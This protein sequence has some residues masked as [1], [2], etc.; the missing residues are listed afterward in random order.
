MTLAQPNGNFPEDTPRLAAHHDA[1]QRDGTMNA[2]DLTAA[3]AQRCD[4][5]HQTATGWQACC[6]AHE[7]S[8]PSLAITPGRDKVLLKCHA[9]CTV[10]AIVTALGMTMADLFLHQPTTHGRK[11][12]VKV[13]DYLDANGHVL[14]QTVRYADPKDFKQRRPDP[15]KPGDYIWSLKGIEPVLYHLPDVLAAV[16]R[17]ETVYLCEGEKDAENVQSL[18]LTATTNP[19]GAAYWRKSY[20]ETLRGAAVVLL[21]DHDEAGQKRTAKVAPALYG[22]VASLKVLELPGLAEHGDVSD[23]LAAGGTRASLEALVGD[24][25]VW[26]STARLTPARGTPPTGTPAPE[27]GPLPYSDYTNACALVR[28]HGQDLRYCHPWHVWLTWTGSHWH[29]D[30]TGVLMRNAKATIKRMAQRAPDLDDIALK[31]LLAHVKS[32]LSTAKLKAMIESAESEPAI[33]V[34]PDAL[35]AER[36]LLNC[37]NG[38]LDLRTGTLRPHDRA[39]LLTKSLAVAYDPHA[40]CPTWDAFLWRILGGTVTPDSP[41]DGAAVFEARTAADDRATR[42]MGFLQRAIGYSLTGETREQCLFVLHGSG[43][44][45]KSTFLDVLQTLLG[46]YAQSTPSASLLAKDRHD[47]IP[48]DIARLRGARLVTAVEIGEGKRLNEELIKRLTGQDLMTARFLHA[49]FFD[50]KPEF[51]LFIACNHLPTIRGTDHAIWRRV[52]LL[53]F[54][55]TIPDEQQDKELPAKLHAEVPGILAWA[56]HGCLDWQNGG[57]R[58][59]P[60]V[61]AATAGYRASMDVIGRFIDECCLVSPSVQVKASE[62]YDIFKKWCEACNEY[63]GSLT[64]F[65]DRLGEKGFGKRKSNVVWYLGI[66]LNK[67]A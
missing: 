50:F 61:I 65:G 62:L 54:T 3:I 16:Q 11:H 24:T 56:V 46:D 52:K 32:S 31:A 8:T 35:D 21:P 66:G 60:E 57:L 63:A 4:Q 64:V 58:T 22:T 55:V 23:W 26:T 42:L 1:R 27:D 51:K 14:H 37:P 40:R 18:G 44:N 45:G 53:P 15:A 7:D 36:W 2:D 67:E 41:D 39:D 33:P 5:A 17:G 38:T 13:Y 9:G 30:E 25:P 28:A 20:T 12:I 48:N 34:L 19:M 47:G 10:N 49:E 43:A 29:P 59:P 6:P